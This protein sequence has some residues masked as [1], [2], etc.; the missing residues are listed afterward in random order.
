MGFVEGGLVG[1]RVNS[2]LS[3]PTYLATALAPATYV[4]IN[5]FISK[6]NY[7]FSRYQSVIIVIINLLTTSSIG[8]LGILISILLCTQTIRIRYIFSEQLSVQ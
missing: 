8:Y 6:Q 4:S 7:I 3:E 5:N 1:F 2:I